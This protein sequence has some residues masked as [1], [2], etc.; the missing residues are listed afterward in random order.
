MER[1]PF[2]VRSA[3]KNGVRKIELS[4]ENTNVLVEV[5]RNRRVQLGAES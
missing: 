2:V 5:E 4:S 3:K 1:A